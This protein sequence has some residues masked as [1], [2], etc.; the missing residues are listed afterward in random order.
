MLQQFGKWLGGSD[1]EHKLREISLEFPEA[2]LVAATQ[3]FEP[4][5]RLGSGN[6]G[7]VYR[8]TLR[9]GHDVAIKVME[10]DEEDDDGAS[11]FADE[12]RVLSKFRHPN[13]VTLMGWGTGRGRQYLVYELLGG[14]DV[15][16][17]LQSCRTPDGEPFGWAERLWVALDAACGLSHMHNSTPKAFHRDIKSA[18]ILLDRSGSA[19]MADFGLS[20]IAKN[21]GKLN[22]TCEQISGTPGY[23]CPHYIK[24]GRVSEGT[25]VYAFG[26]VMLELLLNSMP[27]CLGQSGNIIYPIF[28]VV[29]PQAAGALDRA[30]AALDPKAGWPPALAKDMSELALVCSDIEEARRPGFADVARRL[31]QFTDQFCGGRRPNQLGTGSSAAPSAQMGSSLG[32][33]LGSTPGSNQATRPQLGLGHAPGPGAELPTRP[34]IGIGPQRPIW[35]P[36]GAAKMPGP[37]MEAP[38]NPQLG[39]AANSPGVLG[40]PTRPQ[41]AAGYP[42]SPG[43]DPPTRPQLGLGHTP[44]AAMDPPTRPQMSAVHA[45]SSGNAVTATSPQ[46]YL[47][48][49]SYSRT[50]PGPSP[51]A[52]AGLPPQGRFADRVKELW[53]TG[54]EA[55]TEGQNSVRNTAHSA[56]VPPSELAESVLECV[57]ASGVDLTG[58]PLKHRCVVLQA[59]ESTWTVGR[60]QQPNL[61]ARIVP[62]EALRTVISRSHVLFTLEKSALR[63]KKL[64]P[65]TVLVNGQ[66]IQQQDLVITQGAQIGFCGQDNAT[67]FLVFSVLLR[68]GGAVP[69]TRPMQPP[70]NPDVQHSTDKMQ[71]QAPAWWF[72]GPHTPYSLVCVLA[73]G[74]DIAAQP[75]QAKSIGLPADARL[76]VG[77][78]HQPG[79]FEGVLGTEAAQRYL[80]CVSRSHLEVAATPGAPPGCFD[81]TNLS[82]NPVALVGQRRLGKGEKGS[83]RPGDIIDFIGGSAGGS[84]SP[85]V[86]LKLQLEGQQSPSTQMEVDRKAIRGP[87]QQAPTPPHAPQTLPASAQPPAPDSHALTPVHSPAGSPGARLLPAPEDVAVRSPRFSSAPPF[88]LEL[89]GSAVRRDFPR[90]RRRLEGRE[91]GLTVGRAQQQAL[92][93]EAFEVELR[94]YLSRE[95]FRIERGRDGVCRLVPMSSNPI[96][97]V[98]GGSQTEAVRGDPALLLAHGDAIQ[99]FTGAEDCTIDGPGNLGT[100]LWLF[101]ES[102]AA[103]GGSPASSPNDD[104]QASGFFEGRAVSRSSRKRSTSARRRV[105][106][107]PVSPRMQR[108]GSQES[109]AGALPAPVFGPDEDAE[110]GGRLRDLSYNDVNDKFAASGFRY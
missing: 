74:F 31:R 80:C 84:G 57:H 22:M 45:P 85:V 34:Q 79:F 63:M 17:R 35:Q 30:L 70:P 62:D 95:H 42:G 66:P 92:H 69:K 20:G 56:G 18:N 60:Q 10:V 78:V 19:K 39:L 9:D 87:Q 55:A 106:G 27:A 15:S 51:E 33:G 53:D 71:S 23:A 49:S 13:L 102:N 91:D 96:W 107:S 37:G 81:V 75:L 52:S 68:E 3:H 54:W 43:M 41:M 64:S 90:D 82:A 67:A 99:L 109:K 5:R 110:R 61:F 100:L 108:T 38:T 47:H 7:A 6:Y 104:E 58:M 4:S 36:A 11:G 98:R 101:Q 105:S 2:E 16:H 14:G 83:V 65:N 1:A 59:G 103:A 76:T 46:M 44:K 40:S 26:M 72:A 25:E 50:T 89:R 73:W 32:P 28:Q 77:R 97:R 21:K 8:G 86:Y 48:P 88:W 12:V 94:Q 24:S 93:S 29:M